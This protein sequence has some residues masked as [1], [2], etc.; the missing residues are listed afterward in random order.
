MWRCGM[1][2][3]LGCVRDLRIRRKS[4]ELGWRGWRV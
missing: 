2:L 4:V 3:A 1:T